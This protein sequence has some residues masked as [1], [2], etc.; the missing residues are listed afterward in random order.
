MG[1]KNIFKRKLDVST[2]NNP[3]RFLSSPTASIF[4]KPIR[5]LKHKSCTR[6]NTSCSGNHRIQYSFIWN[7]AMNLTIFSLS[8]Q[9]AC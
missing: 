5:V 7:K 2:N 4:L 9:S 8:P 6:N 3:D 1:N